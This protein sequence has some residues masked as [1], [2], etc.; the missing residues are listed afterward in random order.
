MAKQTDRVYVIVTYKRQ[1]ILLTD[2]ALHAN[3][4]IP[5]AY[6]SVSK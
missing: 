5:A 2:D 4:V 1:N 6:S 3:A